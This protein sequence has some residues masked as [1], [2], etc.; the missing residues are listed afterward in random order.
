METDF[1]LQIKNAIL[2]TLASP[3]TLIRNQIASLLAQI[4]KIEIPRNEWT[5]LIPNMC[6]NSKSG[7]MNIRLASLKT[8]GYLC[9]EL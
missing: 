8:L 2:A 3:K 4:G 5:E 9:E 6:I 1:K 7:D